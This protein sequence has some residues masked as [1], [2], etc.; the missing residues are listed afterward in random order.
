[1]KKRVIN[2]LLAASLICGM[3]TG[4]GNNTEP[5]MGDD[6]VVTLQTE[7][8]SVVEETLSPIEASTP[9]SIPEPTEEPTPEPTEEPEPEIAMDWFADQDLEITPQGDFTYSAMAYDSNLVDLTTFE[10]KANAVISE[11]TEG[12]EEGYKEVKL[13]CTQDVNAIYN[14]E[15]EAGV[16]YWTSAFD[17]YTGTSFEFDSSTT[18]T[19]YG[20]LSDK[21]GYV[22]IVNGDVSYEVSIHFESINNFP[23]ITKSITVTCPVD[24]DGVVFQVGYW[25]SEKIDENQT[26][27]YTAR[28]YTIDELPAWGD[29]YYYFSYSNE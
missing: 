6:G 26:I 25:D 10:V 19:D 13:V 9:D 27:D 29:G 12:V 28:L 2:L 20:E 1:M 18:Y 8:P 3:L 21:Q 15:G 11:T 7:E 14:I 5:V 23:I 17:R 4:C 24:Y 22:T 16:R